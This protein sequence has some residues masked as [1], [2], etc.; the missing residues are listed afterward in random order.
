MFSA[1][2]MFAARPT[3]IFTHNV[4]NT[5]N[6]TRPLFA[7]QQFREYATKKR[8]GLFKR[9]VY[10]KGII[11]A[12]EPLP[13]SNFGIFSG[14]N[15]LSSKGQLECLRVTA[16][17]EVKKK[18][19][20]RIQ[21]NPNIPITKK[22]AGVRMG[23]GKGPIKEYKAQLRIGSCLVEL[24]ADKEKTLLNIMQ[25]IQHKLPV[26]IYGYNKETK[27]KIYLKKKK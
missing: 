6:Y 16:K 15:F 22:A 11:M 26:P 21:A 2:S 27:K 24:D 19:L 9:L 14:G 17:R 3:T 1:M 25:K 4:T 18:G 12:K 23:K 7:N 5:L 20:V 10:R 8:K 13:T